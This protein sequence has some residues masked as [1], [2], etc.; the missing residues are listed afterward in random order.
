MYSTGPISSITSSVPERLWWEMN[1][2][3]LTVDTRAVGSL[4][5]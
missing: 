1:P 3:Y 4:G 5:V 2:S